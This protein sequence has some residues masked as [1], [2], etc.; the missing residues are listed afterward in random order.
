MHINEWSHVALRQDETLVIG[1]QGCLFSLG[2]LLRVGSNVGGWWGALGGR[3]K[4]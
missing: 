2:R 1:Y 4:W 3:A